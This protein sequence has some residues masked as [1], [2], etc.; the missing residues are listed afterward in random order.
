MGPRCPECYAGKHGN[1]TGWVLD[2]HDNE[3]ECTCICR[4]TTNPGE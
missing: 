1:C 2:D 3:A 4:S